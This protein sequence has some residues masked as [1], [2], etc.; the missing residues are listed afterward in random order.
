M[1]AH[2][3]QAGVGGSPGHLLRAMRAYELLKGFSCEQES[4][5]IDLRGGTEKL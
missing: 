3:I 5:R 2:S 1:C 4:Y